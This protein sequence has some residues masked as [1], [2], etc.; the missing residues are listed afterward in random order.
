MVTCDNP[1]CPERGLPKDPGGYDPAVIVCGGCG[2]PVVPV[3][4]EDI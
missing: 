1:E 4:S 3:E 2:Q